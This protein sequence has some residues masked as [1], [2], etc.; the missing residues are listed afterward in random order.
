MTDRFNALAALVASGHA[1]AAQALAAL[2]RHVQG[3]SPGAGQVVC[4]AGRAPDRGGNV[5]PAVRS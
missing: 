3:R 2:P 1:L 5:L 4:T